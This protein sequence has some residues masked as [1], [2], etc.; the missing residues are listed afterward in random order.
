[1]TGPTPVSAS[2]A[3]KRRDRR[4]PGRPAAAGTR[5]AARMSARDLRHTAAFTGL[6]FTRL[7]GHAPALVR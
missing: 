5:D 1:M 2:R 6:A 7:A 3:G 4:Y